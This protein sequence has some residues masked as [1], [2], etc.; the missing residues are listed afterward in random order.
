MS[1]QERRQIHGLRREI[2][3]LTARVEL[4]D[5][6]ITQLVGEALDR[7]GELRDLQAMRDVLAPAEHPAR[8]GVEFECAFAPS[9]DGV[10]GDFHLV[11]PGP[12][13]DSTVL[14]VGDVSG[15]GLEAAR[16][17]T[18]VRTALATFAGFVDD[19]CQLLQLSNQVLVE[20]T[21]VSSTFVTAI[22]AVL[23]PR[24]GRVTW[25]SAGHPP[26]LRLDSGETL[27]GA[28]S[29]P[30]LGVTASLSCNAGRAE[31]D[32]G[33]GLLLY[34]DGVTEAHRPRHELFGEHRLTAALREQAGSEPAAVVRRVLSDLYTHVGGTL[35]D[36][37]CI[38]AAR[39]QAT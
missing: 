5:G 16:R 15:K 35:G 19:P 26:P 8:P 29:S 12:D 17:A 32:P 34:T 10:A 14:A 30:P 23:H 4:R 1:E 37:L 31:L 39:V 3:E 33:A 28:R 21:G 36:D 38:V 22:A 20:R 24:E 9:A 27:N 6:R 7:D 2:A 11:A 25:S 13:E 18:F